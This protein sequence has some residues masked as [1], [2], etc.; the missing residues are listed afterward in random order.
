MGEAE[1]IRL[2]YD[3]K[4]GEMTGDEMERWEKA[5]NDAD[6]LQKQIELLKKEDAG[7]AWAEG[8]KDVLKIAGKSVSEIE[9][10]T[11]E[12]KAFDKFLRGGQSVLGA[13]DL[14]SLKA[15]QADDMGGGG[16][17]VMPMELSNQFLTLMKDLVFIRMYGTV[18]SVTNADSIGVPT[19]DTDP[20]DDDWT[21]ELRTGSEE[22]TTK[23]GGR[24]MK[25]NPFAK[26]LKLSRTLIRKA[27]Q[28]EELFLDRMA[29][30]VQVTEEK[31]FLTGD[32]S[33][34]PLGLFTASNNGI[35]TN[36]DV[37]AAGAAAITA[38]DLLSVYFKLKAQYRRNARWVVNRTVLQAIRKLKD[39]N[40]NYIWSTGL[41]PGQGFDGLAPTL[42][43][44]PYCES[45]Y[46]PG[47][48]TSTNYTAI[49]GDLSFYWIAD[50]LDTT[51]QV[52]DQLY[53]ETNQMGY[54]LRK[55]TDGQ[56]V[57]EEAFA[58]LKQA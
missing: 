32:G 7:R 30:K 28:F 54:I 27:P 41:G 48:I 34:K 42:M 18:L 20:S 33:Q 22:G 50:A 37:V 58:R 13:Q 31:A 44:L 43:G 45:E 49:L 53:A 14:A 55:E 40:N 46:A 1:A 56:P 57:L 35:S 8:V 38:D 15:Y 47:S 9:K 19:I 17:F 5:V 21:T 23:A 24:V 26:R 36:R 11:A 4:P 2:K 29:Y 12:R 25:P 52:L 16:F 10:D 3:G 51:V 39:S 6:K